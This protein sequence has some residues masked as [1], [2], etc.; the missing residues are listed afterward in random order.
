[1]NHHQYDPGKLLDALRQA[2]KCRNDAEL[3]KSLH[4]SE[5]LITQVR[6]RHRPVTGAMLIMMHE[7]SGLSIAELRALMDDRRR[8]CRMADGSPY[9]DTSVDTPGRPVDAQLS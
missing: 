4:M 2:L 3:S 5:A 8:S 7:A 9:A 6:E 1:L